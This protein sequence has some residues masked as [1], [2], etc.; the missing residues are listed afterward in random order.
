MPRMEIP[1]IGIGAGP[2]HRRPGA[3]LPRPARHLRRP[4]R[5]LREALRGRPRARW[6]R[7]STAFAD[8]VR[9]RRYPEPEHGY[10]MAPDE[11]ARLHELLRRADRRA[12]HGRALALTVTGASSALDRGQRRQIDITAGVQSVV[13]R[14]PA[15]RSGARVACSCPGS[16]AAITTMEYEPGGVHDLGEALDRLVPREGDYEHNRLNQTPTPTPTSGRRSSGPRR[17]FRCAAAACTGHL[18]ADRPRGLRRPPARAHRGR[19]GDRL[20]TETTGYAPGL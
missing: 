1:V 18:A 16:T 14:S 19:A 7:A 8:D 12:V 11:I 4:R 9:A 6:S 5:A 20:V 2:G 15:S 10:T 3:G 13:D 17:R